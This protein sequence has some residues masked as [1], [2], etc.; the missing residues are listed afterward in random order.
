M[1]TRR[2]EKEADFVAVKEIGNVIT[3]LCKGSPEQQESTLKAYFLPNASFTH[4][5]CRVPSFSKGDVPLAAGVDSLWVILGV[6][7][8]YRTMS[9]HIDITVD[10]AGAFFFLLLLLSLAQLSLFRFLFRKEGQFLIRGGF[11]RAM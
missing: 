9:P 2:K 7:R 5:F 4:P 11:R 6:Y 8:W 10:S 3:T 1:G